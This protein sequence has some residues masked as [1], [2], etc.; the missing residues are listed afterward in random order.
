MY[1]YRNTLVEVVILA[2]DSSGRQTQDIFKIQVG[3]LVQTECKKSVLSIN[4]NVEKQYVEF[5]D[6]KA[7]YFELP[8]ISQSA[9]TYFKT[10]PE[11]S[12]EDCGPFFYQQKNLQDFV[13]QTNQ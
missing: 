6:I 1:N 2:I 4:S 3:D 11:F 13:S 12:Q 8:Q 7:V 10:L 5:D 9:V